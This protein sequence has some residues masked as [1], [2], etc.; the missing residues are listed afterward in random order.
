MIKDFFV[1]ALVHHLWQIASIEQHGCRDEWHPGVT[2][3]KES[4]G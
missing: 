3:T 1:A 2:I 4:R